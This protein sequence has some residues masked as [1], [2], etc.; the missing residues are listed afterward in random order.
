MSK[1]GRVEIYDAGK[2]FGCCVDYADETFHFT[3]IIFF[4]DAG[5][6][7]YFCAEWVKKKLINLKLQ[8]NYKKA[9]AEKSKKTS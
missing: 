6:I 5:K 8:E 2:G 1:W 4:Q 7:S 3:L 9:Q